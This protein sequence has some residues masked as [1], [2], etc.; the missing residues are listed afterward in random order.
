[1]RELAAARASDISVV[2]FECKRFGEHHNQCLGVL[3]PPL[4]SVLREDF[5][6]E[7]PEPLVQR[8]IVGYVLAAASD[9]V[10]LDCGSD[11]GVSHAVRRVQF[12]SFLLAKAQERG[13]NLAC[14]RVSDVEFTSDG[15][16][17]Y[18]DSG[19]WDVDVV[20]GAFGLDRSM[21]DV[22]R[23]RTKY[24]PPVAIETMVTK[25]H[26]AGIDRL[27][28]LLSDR[29]YVYL[30]SIRRIE[31]GA[32]VP[33]GNHVSVIV[34]GKDIRASDMDAFLDLP[35]VSRLLPSETPASGYFKGSF[36]LGLA[37]G[38]YGDRYVM[39]GDA[40]GLVRPFKGKGINTAIM[41]GALAARTIVEEGV[42][43]AALRTF[44]AG[45]RELESDV[46]YG[47]FMRALA[48]A[49]ANYLSVERVIALARKDRA[50]NRALFDCV[51]GNRP[52]R[53]IVLGNLNLRFVAGVLKA[54][55]VQGLLDRAFRPWR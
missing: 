19:N 42:S 7:L 15:A 29:I 3:S 11:A 6:I 55:L 49:T 16:T 44:Y 20:V 4:L 2:L 47:R 32:L 12:D 43:R 30:P 39:V 24:R 22:F 40:A 33:K 54:T 17:V 53:E 46:V 41:T 5:G 27:E 9:A 13:V 35:E 37:S 14:S 8:N 52:F 1:L 25:I 31:F 34:A 18:S 10:T 28:G 36:P 48:I 51:S 23:K 38:I 26:P 50:V 45:C 21:A